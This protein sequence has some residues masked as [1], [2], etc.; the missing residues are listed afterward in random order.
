MQ[1][2]KVGVAHDYWLGNF[3]LGIRYW[4][5]DGGF[6]QTSTE[7]NYQIWQDMPYNGNADTITAI[8][9][10]GYYFVKWSD[11]IT[12]PQRTDTNVLATIEIWAIFKKIEQ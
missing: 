1:G 2:Q 12:T 11:G 8:P 10:P 6:L 7:R 9:N 5:T 4:A 3:N